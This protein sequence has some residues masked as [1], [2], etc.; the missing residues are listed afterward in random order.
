MYATQVPHVSSYE[1]EFIAVG[2]GSKSGDAIVASWVEASGIRRIVVID[3][4][5]QTTGEKVVKLVHDRFGTHFIDL[6]FST[7]PDED[8]TNGL[9][10]VL[11]ECTVSELLMHQPWNHG[12]AGASLYAGRFADRGLR[13]EA[14]KSLDAVRITA[15]QALETDVT[16][17]E[18]FSGDTRFDGIVEILGPTPAFYESLLPGFRA[19][20]ASTSVVSGILSKAG[21]LATIVR[22]SLDVETLTDAGETSAEND[23]SAIVQLNFNG[24]RVML[25]GDAGIPALEGAADY[26]DLTYR[27]PDSLRLI[28]VPHHGSKRN[29][30]PTVLDRLLGTKLGYDT[31]IRPAVVSAAPDGAPKHPARQVTNAFRRRGTPV[32]PTQ[33][34]NIRLDYNAPLAGWSAATPL[35]LYTEVEE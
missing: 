3:G 26:L 20:G 14:M 29:V 10:V 9:V 7:H 17:N 11:E 12:I 6:I 15:E 16:V 23:S 8:H 32:Y 25:T 31:T 28:Q 27:G 4:G 34:S 21:N 1:I 2:E 5:Y 35:P 13:V 22:E 24:Q 18:P 33:G 19:A 30:G